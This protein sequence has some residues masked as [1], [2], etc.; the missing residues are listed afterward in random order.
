MSTHTYSMVV[1][2]NCGGQFSQNVLHYQFDDGG[3]SNTAD[4]AFDLCNAFDVAHRADLKSILSAHTTI[5]SLKGRA[6]NVSGGFEGILTLPAAQ[7]GTRAGNLSVSAVGPVVVLYPNAN[8]KQRG[9]VFLP[10]LSDAD[11][12]YGNLKPAY[13]TAFAAVMSI[14]TGTLTLAGGGSPVAS[15]VIYSR[16][17][18]PA[19]SRIVEYAR[20]SEMLGTQRRR[21]RPA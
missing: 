9:R 7:V 16:K 19:T 21:Q 13:K 1:S 4:A 20:L 3:Y 8:A 2:Y 14:F 12:D 18:L 11:A 10:G 6:L 15:P 5:L 17:P